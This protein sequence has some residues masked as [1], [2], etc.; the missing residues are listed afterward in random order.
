MNPERSLIHDRIRPGASD[1]LF[2]GDNLAGALDQGDQNIEC[3]AA[4]A[5]RLLIF[6][7]Q[8]LDRKQAK[9]AKSQR[10]CTW[11][12]CNIRHLC[13]PPHLMTLAK[14]VPSGTLPR[15]AKGIGMRLRPAKS[16]FQL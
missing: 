14:H 10:L 4:K 8:A 7:Q 12:V 2:L 5:N 15:E 3:A 16:V 1:E 11:H 9:G 13:E 6:Q